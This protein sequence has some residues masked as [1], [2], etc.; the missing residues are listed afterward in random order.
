MPFLLP[1]V[2]LVLIVEWIVY[3]LLAI[4]FDHVLAD[5]NGG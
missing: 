3:F 2:W 5:E 1:A 4:Y